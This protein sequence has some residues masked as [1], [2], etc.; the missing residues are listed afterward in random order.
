MEIEIPKG[1]KNIIESLNAAGYEAYVVGGCVRDSLMH[2]KPSDWD[3][4]TSA[5]AQ[6]MLHIFGDRRVIPTGLKHGTITLLEKDGAYEVTTFR[7]DGE[8]E[9]HR[10]PKEVVFTSELAEDLGRRD[11]TI[12]AMAWHPQKGLIDMYGGVD[13]L[14]NR[15]VRAV[16]EPSKR[17][18]EDGLRMLRMVSFATVLDFDDDQAT[19]EAAMQQSHLLAYISKER[20]QV[21]LNKTLLAAHPA[22]GLEDLYTLGMYPHIIPQMC[23]TVGFLQNG[24]HHFLDVFEHSILAVGLVER[25][26][27]LRLTMLLHDIAKPFTWEE[28]TEKGYDSFSNHAEVGAEIANK[29]LRNLKYDNATRKDVVALIRTHNDILYPAELNIRQNLAKMGEVQLRRLIKVKVADLLAHDLADGRAQMVDMFSEIE[30]LLNQIIERGDCVAIKDL[31]INGK[32]MQELGIKGRAIGEM[33]SKALEEVIEHPEKNERGTLI[34][35]CK[36]LKNY[37]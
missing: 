2:K 32:D 29:I 36:L 15:L 31:A 35:L 30:T 34:E 17:F 5:P 14:K 4:C 1:A 22:R 19:F 20:I 8:Y 12:N 13:D 18:D 26:L 3:I 7:I 24:G 9:D 6:E 21:E 37:R 11:F 10:H 25:D 27:V 33:L 28:N 23:H 16:G